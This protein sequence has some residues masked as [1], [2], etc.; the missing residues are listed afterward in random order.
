M[1]ALPRTADL[2][3]G[4]WRGIL[5]TLT[6]YEPPRSRTQH[7][8]CPLG[9]GGKRSFRF[10]DKAGAGTWICTHCGAGDGIRFLSRHQ[11]WDI[12]T[13][14]AEVDRIV[15][16]V[17]ALPTPDVPQVTP[18]TL[19]RIWRGAIR[20]GFAVDYLRYRGLSLTSLPPALRAHEALECWRQGDDGKPV[21]V[22]TYPAMVAKVTDPSGKPVA[23]HRTFLLDGGRRVRKALGPV[24]GAA[25]RLG[26]A[27]EVMGVAEGIETAMAA[28]ELYG[29][30]VWS[31]ISDSGLAAFS[32]P[33][34]CRELHVFGDHDASYAGQAAAYALAKR[35]KARGLAVVVS[36]PPAEGEDWLDVLVRGGGA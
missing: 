12:A 7:A 6:G 28:A 31:A 36:I 21:K 18:E 20:P 15:S 5:A 32:P 25:I 9:C 19:N 1:S 34:E 22:G 10:D 23:L 3:R 2:A 33:P 29:M 26:P 17:V 14:F 24:Q 11:G 35:A 13:T 16:T 27:A 4:K 30:P 8:A